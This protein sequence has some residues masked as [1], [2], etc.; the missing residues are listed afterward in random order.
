M[1]GY[2]IFKDKTRLMADTMYA[3]FIMTN[4]RVAVKVVS[5]TISI[6]LVGM[7]AQNKTLAN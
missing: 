7:C 2:Y 4:L 5:E 3:G 6:Y 1:S